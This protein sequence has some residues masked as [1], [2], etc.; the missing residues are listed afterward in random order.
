MSTNRQQKLED[1]KGKPRAKATAK[2]APEAEI[3]L[4]WLTAF[5]K[6]YV[7]KLCLLALGLVLLVLLDLLLSWNQLSVFL[8]LFGVEVLLGILLVWLLAMLKS[9]ARKKAAM[10]PLHRPSLETESEP[11]QDR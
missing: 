5:R 1:N 10:R 11:T 4:E 6:T 9:S 8:I 2:K 3:L 7:G